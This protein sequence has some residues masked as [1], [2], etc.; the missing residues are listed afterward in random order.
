MG[1]DT[2]FGFG[3]N[4]AQE[5]SEQQSNCM[6]SLDCPKCKRHHGYC[7]EVEAQLKGPPPEEGQNEM[8]PRGDAGSNST[9][10]KRA[11]AMEYLQ[12]EALSKQPK[13]AKI[14]AIKADPDNKYGARVILKLAFEGKI[15]FWGVNIKKNP[16]YQLMLDKFGDDENDW[17]DQRILIH[18]EQDEFSGQ[19]FARVS[20]PEKEKTKGGR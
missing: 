17:T 3:C 14:L 1:K 11:G 9:K 8:L 6:G 16:N 15:V 5:E 20:F 19:Y 7:S 2:E 12:N 10:P 4:E 13:E 18:L